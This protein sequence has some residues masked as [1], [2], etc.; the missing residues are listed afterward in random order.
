MD[1]YVKQSFHFRYIKIGNIVNTGTLHIGIV[2]SIKPPPF[3][4]PKV[5]I[6]PTTPATTPQ[7]LAPSVPLQAGAAGT[8][9]RKG[10]KT[11]ELM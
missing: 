6:G 10:L 3:P 2:G 1:K 7:Q 8:G 4:K 5:Q 9:A 11:D